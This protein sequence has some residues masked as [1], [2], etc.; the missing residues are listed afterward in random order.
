LPNDVC[1]DE[2]EDFGVRSGTDHVIGILSLGIG[3]CLARELDKLSSSLGV[4]AQGVDYDLLDECR[5]SR[6]ASTSATFGHRDTLTKLIDEFG[7]LRFGAPVL[8]AFSF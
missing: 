4:A 3:F 7:S 8:A 1:A 5:L 2:L 6:N